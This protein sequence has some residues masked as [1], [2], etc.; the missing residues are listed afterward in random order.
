MKMTEEE[1][2]KKKDEMKGKWDNA[3]KGATATMKE[4]MPMMKGKC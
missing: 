3:K 1:K 4:A 2:K